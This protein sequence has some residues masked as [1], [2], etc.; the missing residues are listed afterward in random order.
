MGVAAADVIS[1]F[2]PFISQFIGFV[3]NTAH[4][5]A[6]WD[7]NITRIKSQVLLAQSCYCKL[8]SARPPSFELDAAYSALL[9]D[10][11]SIAVYLNR[12]APADEDGKRHCPSKWRENLKT[13]NAHLQV[14]GEQLGKRIMS[15]GALYDKLVQSSPYYRHH[16]NNNNDYDDD[17]NNNNTI[18]TINKNSLTLKL[19]AVMAPSSSQTKSFLVEDG[20]VED[21]LADRESKMKPTQTP[22]TPSSGLASYSAAMQEYASQIGAFIDSSFKLR[23]ICVLLS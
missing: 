9:I 1:K 22:S 20:D 19:H 12:I 17:N 14:L 5:H 16:N 7:E 8:Q 23:S 13:I 11:E 18:N 2:I 15:I 21:T 6:L 10:I 4:N 3:R